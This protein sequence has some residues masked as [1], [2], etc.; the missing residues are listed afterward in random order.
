MSPITDN[1]DKLL[2]D[3][4]INTYNETNN[5]GLI[6]IFIR[7]VSRYITLVVHPFDLIETIKE[8]ILNKE[9]YPIKYQRLVYNGKTLDD[10]RSFSDYDIRETDT[11]YLC[12]RVMGGNSPISDQQV[13]FVPEA[14]LYDGLLIEHIQLLKVM[15]AIT[16]GELAPGT[17]QQSERPKV[18]EISNYV[19][20]KYALKDSVLCKKLLELSEDIC[21]RMADAQRVDELNQEQEND[22]ADALG[23]LPTKLKPVRVFILPGGGSTKCVHGYHLPSGNF[24]CSLL[25][26]AYALHPL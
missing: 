11:I 13:G 14:K 23:I 15:F 16:S 5:E 2:D 7:C 21:I 20:E 10:K 12:L 3:S 17:C 25:K 8:K 1:Y 24:L 18:L 9:G 22:R 4:S 26:L 6:Q 19:W